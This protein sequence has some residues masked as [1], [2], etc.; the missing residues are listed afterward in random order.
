[1][2]SQD[3]LEDQNS[4]APYEGI[5]EQNLKNNIKKMMEILNK[6]EAEIIKLR[7]GIG[8]KTSLIFEQIAVIFNVTRERIRQ[9]VIKALRRLRHQ[10]HNTELA[11]YLSS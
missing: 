4:K 10:C 9:I 3:L 11:L 1:M 5:Q 2:V 6:R 7:Y 8:R